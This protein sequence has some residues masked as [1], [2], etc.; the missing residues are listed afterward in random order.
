[1]RNRGATGAAK[2]YAGRI[3][4]AQGGTL[5]LDEIGELPLSAQSKLL[6]FLEQKEVQR[7][8]SAEVTRVDVRVVAATNRNIAEQV[9]QGTFRD[10]PRCP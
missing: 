5:F 6:R 4:A 9:E 8:G 10:D 3:Q 2:A 7:L 1:M